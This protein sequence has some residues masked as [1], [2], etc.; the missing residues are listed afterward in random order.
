MGGALCAVFAMSELLKPKLGELAADALQ[1]RDKLGAGLMLAASAACIALGALGGV[2]AMG[3]ANGPRE[4]HDAAVTRATAAEAR[5]TDAQAR[6]DAVPTCTPEM[7]A[8]RCREQTEQNAATV[9]D[10]TMT[11]DEAKQ[12]RDGAKAVLA[13]LPDPGPGLP[14]VALWQKA[15][16]IAAI[17]FV[18][19]AVPFAAARRRKKVLAVA[20]AD[21]PK[22]EPTKH[23]PA[24]AK[25]GK[26]NDG[27]WAA[28]RAKY[29]KSG[30]K[31]KRYGRLG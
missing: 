29:G 2:I 22:V 7:P 31:P 27:G 18:L 12:E 16:V 23:E 11:R 28:R 15:L 1:A 17:E 5:L 19:F 10:R 26:I 6:L 4:A 14:H 30:R 24:P 8:S 3:A 25:P 13:S 20:A 9:A 21:A